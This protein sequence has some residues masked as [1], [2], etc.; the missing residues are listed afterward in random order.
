MADVVSFPDLRLGKFDSLPITVPMYLTYVSEPGA[1]R[2]MLGRRR[3]KRL[4]G[5]LDDVF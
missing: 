5:S 2:L 3:H 4:F 1:G